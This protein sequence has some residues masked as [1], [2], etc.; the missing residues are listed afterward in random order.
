MNVTAHADSRL[1]GPRGNWWFTGKVPGLENIPGVEANG[2]ITSLALPDLSTCDQQSVLDYFDNTWALQE[3][4]FAGLQ[5]AEAFYRPPIH[6]L[7]HPMIFYYGHPAALYVNKLR[8]SGLVDEPVNPYL[9]QVLETGVDEMSWDDLSKNEML[10]PSVSEV[11]A[12]R[13]LVHGLVRGII[14][15]TD[16]AAELGRP[17]TMKDQA[18]ALFMAFEHDRIHL[19]TS[20]VLIRELPLQLVSRHPVWPAPAPIRRTSSRG[21]PDAQAVPVNRMVAI[22][23]GEVQLGKSDSFPSYGWDNEYGSRT[24]DVADFETSRFLVSNGEYHRFVADGGY[25]RPELWS[26]EGWEWRSFRNAKWPQFWVPDGPSGLH[27]YRLRTTF[28]ELD[29]PWDWPVCVNYHEAK[30]YCS[31]LGSI[32]SRGYRLPTEAEQQCIRELP[33]VPGTADDPV[34]QSDGADLRSRGVNLNLAWGSEGPVDHSPATS[35]GVHD[36][37]GNLWEWSEDTFNPLESFS[38][39]PYYEDF[40]TPCFDGKHHM[41]LGGAFISTGDE[42]SIW[43][44]FHFRPH[45]LQQSGIRLVTSSPDAGSQG[46]YDSQEVLDRYLL[47]HFAGAEDTFDGTDHLLMKAHGYPQRLARL[48]LRTAERKQADLGRV[49]EL[50]C[51]VG[52]TSF[53]LAEGGVRNVTGVDLSPQFVDTAQRL[54]RG[55]SVPYRRT[56][57][58]ENGTGLIASAP[59]PAEGCN[60]AFLVADACTLPCSLG[61][62]DAV[63]LGNLLDRVA[64]PRALLQQFTESDAFLSSG[65]LLLVATPWSWQTAYTEPENWLGGRQ[66]TAT[67]ETEFR[68]L[69]SQAF[70]AVE[71]TEEP[72]VLRN[73]KRHFEVFSADVSVWRKR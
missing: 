61:H 64:D 62:F 4:L 54:A 29:M 50:G 56:D 11:H 34:M 25:R 6:N 43:A 18:W 10:W 17:V 1:S 55:E 46:P 19:E 57:Q 60:A 40:S 37:A 66:Q 47:M 2:Q 3:V 68:N 28:D 41:I 38:V 22:A 32:D 63:V 21:R 7:R 31:W 39:H 12:Y 58:G 14:E 20:S 27:A 8:V 67:S 35:Q 52:G 16:F 59:R 71:E 15:K 30:A 69:L 26:K 24:L 42:A 5:T 49:L 44:R 33:L 36:T 9:E 72:G 13:A 45:F 70:D 51:A 48:L 73:H 23:G 53:A 65:G